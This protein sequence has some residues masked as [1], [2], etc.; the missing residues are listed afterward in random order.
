MRQ[1][2]NGTG[3]PYEHRAVGVRDPTLV[4][5]TGF[6]DF[7]QKFTT[8][9]YAETFEIPSAFPSA[10]DRSAAEFIAEEIPVSVATNE[11]RC[12]SWCDEGLRMVNY[13]STSP[14]ADFLRQMTGPDFENK[15]ATPADFY[16]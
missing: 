2:P 15:F 9:T 6:L 16:G 4:I 1:I 14:Q 10:L 11:G 5:S 7:V 3:T 12:A 8:A 13:A